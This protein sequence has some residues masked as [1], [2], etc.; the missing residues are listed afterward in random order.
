MQL[1]PTR[2][3]VAMAAANRALLDAR[4]NLTLREP[5]TEKSQAPLRLIENSG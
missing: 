4:D 3:Q 5:Q 2:K 1:S